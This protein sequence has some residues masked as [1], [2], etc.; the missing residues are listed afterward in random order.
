MNIFVTLLV[1]LFFVAVG[2]YYYRSRPVEPIP[3][4]GGEALEIVPNPSGEYFLQTDP[5]WSSERIGGSGETMASVGCTICSVA[6][7]SNELG[8]KTN[9]KSF[10]SAL[11]ENGGFTQRGWI[12]WEKIEAASQGKIRV[13]VPGKLSHRALDTAL[14]NG[15]I[16]IAKFYLPSGITHWV[17]IVGKSGYEYLVKDPLNQEKKVVQLSEYTNE[18]SDI[19]FLKK[20]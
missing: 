15:H 7:A 18:I 6:M 4:F 19:R 8:V 9:P 20:R 11:L 17:T 10:N 2:W 3:S 5:Q 16:P 12:I 1:I 13:S 14:K